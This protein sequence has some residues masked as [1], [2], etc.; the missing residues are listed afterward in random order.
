MK[1]ERVYNFA[2]GPSQ[3]PAE[4]LARAQKDLLNYQ[5]S[6]MS[7]M[8]MSHRSSLFQKIFDHAD[9]QFRKV[10]NIPDSYDVLYLQG[11][12]SLQFAMV[13]MNLLGENRKAEY[14]VTG[15]FS[16]KACQEAGRY[17][18]IS[19]VYNGEEN[20]FSHIPSQQELVLHPD[21]AYFHYCA[22][23]TIFGTEWAYVPDT[24][25]VPLVADM[26]SDIASK[27]VDISKFAIIYAGAQKNLAPAGVTV[28]IVKKD[29]AFHP[30]P[31]TPTMLRYKTHMDKRSMYNT[32]PCWQIYMLG[33][34]MDWIEEQGGLA[35]M[36]R[37]RKERAG[38]LYGT[39]E[40]F[41]FYHLH[42][43]PSS[44]SMMNVTFRT[45]S[46]ELDQAFAA[47]AA[48]QGLVNLKGHR[49]VGGLRVSIYNAMP[50]A[51]VK[52]LCLFI[53]AFQKEHQGE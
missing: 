49:L 21:C 39:L 51:G 19:V 17:G 26:S 22:N 6:G 53:E 33:L 41:G 36:E 7:V 20:G 37:R 23:N 45:P 12:A 18:E 46:E 44:R 11:G 9:Q 16:R 47:E 42:A 50:L 27:P 48:E 8:E 5:G 13:P 32:P 35:E 52:K 3:L 40:E 14:V 24:H 29:L 38:L 28:V 1:P 10:M 43:E 4:V 31:E 2:A 15:N 30:L 25:G 34:T